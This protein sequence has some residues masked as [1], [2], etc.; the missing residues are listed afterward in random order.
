MDE[1]EDVV[2]VVPSLPEDILKENIKLLENDILFLSSF[3]LIEKLEN[4]PR[5]FEEKIVYLQQQNMVSKLHWYVQL[6]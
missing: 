4:G 5:Y 3:S 1:E 6:L 2:V